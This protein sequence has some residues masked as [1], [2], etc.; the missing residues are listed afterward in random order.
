MRDRRRSA[1]LGLLFTIGLISLPPQA[2][3]A[4]AGPQF[5][6]YVVES[7]RGW[8]DWKNGLIYGTG[9]ATLKA[10]GGSKIRAQRAAQAIARANILKLAAGVQLDAEHQI[11]SYDG[12]RLEVVLTA[13]LHDRPHSSEYAEQAQEPYFEVTRVAAITGV[14]GLTASLLPHLDDGVT[15]VMETKTAK[16]SGST[17]DAQGPWLLLDAR[18]LASG[19]HLT[20]A[21]FPKI[22]SSSG[23][24]VY[25]RTAVDLDALRERGMVEYVTS[26]IRL[27]E[28]VVNTSHPSAWLR[29]LFGI[30]DAVADEQPRRRRRREFIVS[31]ATGLEGLT[32]T[33]LVVSDDDARRLREADNSNGI[34]KKCRVVVVVSGTVGGVEGRR[35]IDGARFAQA[36]R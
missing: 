18:K 34:L 7:A 8:I 36:G 21:L 17:D 27:D 28:A 33:N 32:R 1:F 10:N 11:G 4:E 3:P 13:V 24:T 15:R 2:G 20:P 5:A 16:P 26:D 30:A 6:P 19:N 22:V 25:Q 12:G 29:T 35:L 23:D 9:K 14:D 31:E